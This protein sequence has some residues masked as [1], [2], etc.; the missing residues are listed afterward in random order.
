MLS[1]DAALFGKNDLRLARKVPE[2]RP[3]SVPTRM[4]QGSWGMRALRRA[5]AALPVFPMSVLYALLWPFE[6]L[7]RLEGFR[8][9]GVKILKYES[10]AV[11]FRAAARTAGSWSDLRREFGMRLPV[12][13]YHH[14]GPRKPGPCSELTI[15]PARF[16]RQAHWLAR[17]GYTGIRPADWVRWR[18]E[19]KGLPEKPILL[20]FDDGYADLAEYAFPVLRRLGFGAAVFLVTGQLGGTNAWDKTRG[21]SPHHL[22]TR[23]QVRYW[24]SQGI[25]FGA[26]SRTHADLTTL[27]AQELADEILGS[28]NDLAALLGSRACAF[29]FP[30]GSYNRAVQDCA[31]SAFDL[32]FLADQ[33][34]SGL[35]DL[36]TDPHLMQRTMVQPNDTLA[37]LECRVR[38]G[39]SP[40]VEMRARLRWRSRWRRATGGHG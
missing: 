4:A 31:R 7:Q 29:A 10:S 35:N 12:L 17:R 21:S 9:W 37:D 14:V 26:H 15:S 39:Y 18:R 33:K 30:Y 20:T 3:Y 28:K 32:T 11:A 1:R 16:E 25:E 2:Y 40:F 36:M 13:L 34:N 19:G 24:A 8:R 23:E 5:V 38:W 6:K 27:S 22:L